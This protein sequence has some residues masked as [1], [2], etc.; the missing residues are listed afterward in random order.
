MRR[1]A[2]SSER[3]PGHSLSNGAGAARCTSSLGDETSMQQPSALV[4]R[5]QHGASGERHGRRARCRTSA[6]GHR[7]SSMWCE[8]NAGRSAASAGIARMVAAAEQESSR[9][10]DDVHGSALRGGRVK[11][12]CRRVVPCA[13]PYQADWCAGTPMRRRR[14]HCMV[15]AGP[16]GDSV[17]FIQAPTAGDIHQTR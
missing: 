3:V 8:R 15:T 2:A 16:F 14:V 7:G 12:P 10:T 5:G 4:T 1:A 6:A 9:G 17:G 13:T 11:A